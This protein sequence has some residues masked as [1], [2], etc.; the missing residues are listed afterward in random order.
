MKYILQENE[1]IIFDFDIQKK[2]KEKEMKYI[3]IW[4]PSSFTPPRKWK[5]VEIYLY[6]FINLNYFFQF[7]YIDT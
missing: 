7:E 2:K 1:I 4:G 3:Y 6:P 5:I